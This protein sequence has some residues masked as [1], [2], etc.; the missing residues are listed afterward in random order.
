MGRSHQCIIQLVICSR[1]KPTHGWVLSSARRSAISS[2]PTCKPLSQHIIQQVFGL[3]V[4][5]VF[6]VCFQLVFHSKT[7]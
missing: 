6:F 4:G 3:E 1:R 5:G 2:D 7:M